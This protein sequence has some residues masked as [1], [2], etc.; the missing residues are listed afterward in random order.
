MYVYSF[1]YIFGQANN[2]RKAFLIDNSASMKK[3]WTEV[4]NVFKGLANIVHN[5]DPDGIDIYF[6]NSSDVYHRKRMGWDRNNW[7]KLIPK[8]QQR[9]LAGTCDMKVALQSVLSDFSANLDPPT[10]KPRNGNRISRFLSP[11]SSTQAK[12]KKG[13][14]VYV[15]T[16]GIWQDSPPPVCGVEQPIR[17]VVEKLDQNSHLDAMVGIQ[18]IRFGE[19]PRGRDRMDL[20]DSK[21]SLQKLD[22]RITM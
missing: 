5:V 19:D 2:R 18:F 16:D 9:Q 21:P 17:H 12:P 10:E 15:L 22:S 1:A 3:H 7:Q 6:T 14:S 4:V 8:I 11:L 13:L 20:L